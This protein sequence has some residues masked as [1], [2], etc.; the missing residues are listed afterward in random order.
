MFHSSSPPSCPPRVDS[1]VVCSMWSMMKIRKDS[2]QMLSTI[3]TPAMAT[4]R[5]PALLTST[6]P[7]QQAG[8]PQET[9]FANFRIFSLFS[10]ASA[11]G[12]CSR[13]LE[14]IGAWLVFA[15]QRFRS[16]QH[17]SRLD[18]AA[19]I[20]SLDGRDANVVRQ[21]ASQPRCRCDTIQ[22]AFGRR[23]SHK[24]RAFVHGSEGGVLQ[25][26]DFGRP[27]STGSGSLQRLP[28]AIM[29]LQGAQYC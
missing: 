4:N 14:S 7:E 21:D 19:P 28:L 10:A 23:H 12:H 17:D 8:H 1:H 22:S 29:F 24:A 20:K 26:L 3:A 27:S 9:M 11:L 2:G 13:H 6:A 5:S 16:R 25:D 18:A 15:L